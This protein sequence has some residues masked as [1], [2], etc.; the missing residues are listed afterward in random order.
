MPANTVYIQYPFELPPTQLWNC[1]ESQWTDISNT[2]NGLFFRVLGSNSAAWK[3]LQDEN[4]TY[5]QYVRTTDNCDNG[6][7]CLD[8]RWDKKPL[9]K[10]WSE[11]MFTSC[12]PSSKNAN[13]NDGIGMQF[14]TASGEV[15]P[16]NM[17]VKIWKCV[18]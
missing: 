6:S 18:A 1:S 10:G 9:N 12:Y 5:I 4:T 14:Y 8:L 13:G 2:Y 7:H 11:P 17:A 15:R 16:R 3:Q